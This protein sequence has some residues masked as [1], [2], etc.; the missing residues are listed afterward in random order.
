MAD[1]SEDGEARYEGK[2]TV[3]ASND[4]RVGKGWLALLTMR[5]VGGHDAERHRQT[6]KDLRDSSAPYIWLLN[7]DAGV[8]DANVLLDAIFRPR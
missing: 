1:A 2:E 3:R 4:A 8:P 5:P 7:E 6:E